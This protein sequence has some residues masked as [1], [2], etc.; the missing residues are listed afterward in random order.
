[1][2]CGLNAT[3]TFGD[4]LLFFLFWVNL[5][6]A[7]HIA[8]LGLNSQLSHKR[9]CAFINGQQIDEP[10]K[11]SLDVHNRYGT[12]LGLARMPFFMPI[13]QIAILPMPRDF[14]AQ[15]WIILFQ[16]SLV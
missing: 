5:S 4:S 16:C 11:V 2:T 15:P 6:V 7:H 12:M 9:Q 8:L 13:T 3:A 1:M 10:G 14:G